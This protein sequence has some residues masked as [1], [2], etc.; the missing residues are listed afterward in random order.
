MHENL[1]RHVDQYSIEMKERLMWDIREGII[2]SS[3][4]IPKHAIIVTWKNMSFAGGLDTTLKRVFFRLLG[5]E[6]RKNQF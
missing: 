4:F 2:G 1:D 6:T 3:E 5:F